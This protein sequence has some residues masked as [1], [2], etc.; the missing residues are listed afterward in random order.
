MGRGNMWASTYL[1]FT[2]RCWPSYRRSGK[3]TAIR[4]SHKQH[5]VEMWEEA[6]RHGSL[7][8]S[9]RSFWVCQYHTH[10][11]LIKLLQT[12]SFRLLMPK[13]YIQR[14]IELWPWQTSMVVPGSLNNMSGW[15]V[16]SAWQNLIV[17]NVGH[18]KKAFTVIQNQRNSFVV[19]PEL[20][21]RFSCKAL[22]TLKQGFYCTISKLKCYCPDYPLI[23]MYGEG[24]TWRRRFGPWLTSAK[25]HSIS[26]GHET[27]FQV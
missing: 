16:R 26:E 21:G 3:E 20:R 6:M 17:V 23:P 9:I 5:F 14:I 2:V 19:W 24:L 25:P 11:A 8:T 22:K 7:M 18:R 27:V 15:H 4:E 10:R 13:P 12:H 1:C